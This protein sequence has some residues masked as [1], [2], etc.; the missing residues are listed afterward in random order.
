MNL[1]RMVN[2]M[3]PQVID[4]S[5]YNSV[6]TLSAAKSA[7]VVGCIHKCSEGT[8]WCDGMLEERYR[9]A[10]EA[11]MLWGL[12]HFMRPGSVSQQVNNF[13]TAAMTVEDENTLWALDYEA[14]GLKLDDVIQFLE[15]IE[16]ATGRSP[17]LYSGHTLREA[18]N[19]KPN[20]AISRYR[21]WL[22]DYTPPP[23]LPP[24]FDTIYLW[25][26]TDSATVP[27]IAGHVDGSTS[28]M[29]AEVLARTW[30]G[31]PDMIV[32]PPPPPP[33]EDVEI[34]VKAMPG[35]NVKITRA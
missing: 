15:L 23:T 30:S 6:S 26:Y 2:D 16:K 10:R 14:S 12:Y 35:I 11:G 21:L 34:I 7:G 22:A 8:T 29:S 24:G 27:G 31:K 3:M 20:E 9:L 5:H 32:T 33:V 19:G 25:Q 17:V 1:C 13:L 28:N 4:L 18:L